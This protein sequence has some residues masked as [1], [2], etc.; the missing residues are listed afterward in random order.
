MAKL[1]SYHLVEIPSYA[2]TTALLLLITINAI[3]LDLAGPLLIHET[4][5]LCPNKEVPR[6]PQCDPSHP[7]KGFSQAQ[8]ILYLI[9]VL[10]LKL[11]RDPHVYVKSER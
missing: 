6:D 2:F 11:S 10:N 5:A 1:D 8:D 7:H 3:Q 4:F 9:S